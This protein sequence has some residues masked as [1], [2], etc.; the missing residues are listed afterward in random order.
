MS[1]PINTEKNDTKF[2]KGNSGKP[3]GAL[4][5]NTKEIKD[6]IN[7]ALH[8]AGGVDYLVARAN[9]PRTASAF[10]SLLGK[11]MPLQVA[12]DPDNPL[13]FNMSVE[14]VKPK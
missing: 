1:N 14:F 11:V 8:Q 4:A 12:G 7:A 9:D 13:K 3:K 10:L 2:R 5:K 6:M